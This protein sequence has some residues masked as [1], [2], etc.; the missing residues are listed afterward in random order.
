MNKFKYILLS[1]FLL[2]HSVIAPANCADSQNAKLQ[3][4]LKVGFIL[5]GAASDLGWNY[6]HD[7]GRQYL[8]KALSG[9]VET[10]VAENVPESAEAE[11]VMEKMIGQGNRLIFSTSYGYLEPTLRVAA[12]HPDVIFMQCQRSASMKNVGTY[13]TN[14]SDLEYVAGYVAG[15]LTK[16]N[17]L[18]YVGGHPVPVVIACIDAF[19]LGAHAANAKTRVKVVWNNSWSDP[20]NESEAAKGLIDSGADMITSQLSTSATVAKVSEKE[21]ALSSAFGSD[22]HSVA[23]KGWL[24]SPVFNWGPLYVKITESVIKQDWKPSNDVYSLK[25]GYVHL[26]TFGP[27]VSPK[28]K[29]EAK[30][31]AD[32][33]ASGQILVFAGPLKDRDGVVR[34]P[35]G[36][37]LDSKT[38][39]T[40][41]WL[42]PNV[43]GSLPKR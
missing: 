40:I 22:L 23:P 41:N 27:A 35:A 32:K 15:R 28:L 18:G 31:V 5:V 38:L 30:S 4:P 29:E 37:S 17:K 2:T 19:A 26:S 34:V 11:R 16:K 9:Q 7:Q 21:G 1:L 14:A 36:K 39:E 3:T 12:R 24:V 13:F 10:S 20:A 25:D 6:E 33:I 8:E 43:D 42:V